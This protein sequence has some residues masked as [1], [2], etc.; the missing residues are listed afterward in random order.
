MEELPFDNHRYTVQ[1]MTVGL[2]KRPPVSHRT[3]PFLFV[4]T[5]VVDT[6]EI[7]VVF[8]MTYQKCRRID[9]DMD[10]M[11]ILRIYKRPA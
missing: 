3:R 7:L 5:T 2:L 9:L 11:K 1:V 6:D 10:K 8:I 4:S